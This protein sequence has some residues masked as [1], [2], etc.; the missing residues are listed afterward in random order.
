MMTQPV[1]EREFLELLKQEWQRLEEDSGCE[2][3]ALANWVHMAS[4][5]EH[6]VDIVDQHLEQPGDDVEQKIRRVLDEQ[7]FCGECGD[8]VVDGSMCRHLD[9]QVELLLDMTERVC[10]KAKR[11]TVHICM[12]MYG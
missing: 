12:P 5:F 8:S 7:Q 11:P 10:R 2:S 4:I 1:M 3:K 6:L 9:R